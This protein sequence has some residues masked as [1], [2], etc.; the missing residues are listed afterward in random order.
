MELSG[1]E[2]F[3]KVYE[4][5]EKVCWLRTKAR[6]LGRLG[7]RGASVDRWYIG[8]ASQRPGA[9]ESRRS[10]VKNFHKISL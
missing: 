8:S 4:L 3:Q 2:G 6:G 9:G 7:G 10:K 1:E 5:R